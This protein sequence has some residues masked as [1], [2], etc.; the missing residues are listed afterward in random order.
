MDGAVVDVQV[1]PGD[2]VS[3]GQL[4]V[5]IEAMKMEHRMCAGASGRIKA[6]HVTVDQQVADR[7]LLVEIE[8][9]EAES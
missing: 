5:V 1:K 8:A 3:R 9:D 2:T 6:V 4:L 7:Q